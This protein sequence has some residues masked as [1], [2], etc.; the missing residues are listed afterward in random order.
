MSI[1]LN[2]VKALCFD[3]LLQVLILKSLAAEQFSVGDQTEGASRNK[4]TAGNLP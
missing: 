4:K 3:R 2:E 1:T